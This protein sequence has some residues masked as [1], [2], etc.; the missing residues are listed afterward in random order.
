MNLVGHG[1]KTTMDMPLASQPV[2]TLASF[3]Q[4]GLTFSSKNFINSH[5]PKLFASFMGKFRRNIDFYGNILYENV[6]FFVRNTKLKNFKHFV[7]KNM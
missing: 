6:T 3:R 7:L 2:S 4:L 1:S 5:E